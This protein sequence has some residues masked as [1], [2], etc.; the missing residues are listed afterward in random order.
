MDRDANKTDRN[1]SFASTWTFSKEYIYSTSYEYAT[2][3]L[4]FRWAVALWPA[5]IGVATGGTEHPNPARLPRQR[6]GMSPG[7]SV[8]A[9]GVS[10]RNAGANELAAG[11]RRWCTK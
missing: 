5:V 4:F 2:V 7:V 8:R 6:W 3:L 10:W 11:G 1:S 9:V